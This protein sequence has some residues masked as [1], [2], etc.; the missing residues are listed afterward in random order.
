MLT[1]PHR[2][3]WF[4][5]KTETRTSDLNYTLVRPKQWK[6]DMRFGTWNIRNLYRS[7]SLT[8]VARELSRYKLDLVGIQVVR[9]DNGGMVRA[10]DY[11]YIYIFFLRKGNHLLG[12][13]Y[14]AHHRIVSAVKIAEFVSDRMSYIFMSCRRRN[15]IFSECACTK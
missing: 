15:I 2:K 12:T 9:W 14:F 7:G 10:G 11:I 6:R 4:C 8:T 13:Q 3:N 5:Y 1:I